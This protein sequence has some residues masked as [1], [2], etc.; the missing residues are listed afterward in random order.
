M[1][2]NVYFM[3]TLYVK[4]EIFERI[5]IAKPKAVFKMAFKNYKKKFGDTCLD[6]IIEFV[7]EWHGFNRA[8]RWAWRMLLKAKV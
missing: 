4:T 8:T 3:R 6:T 5:G 7:N 2:L 1:L